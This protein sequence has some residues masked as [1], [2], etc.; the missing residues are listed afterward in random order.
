[1]TSRSPF[2]L[3][4]EGVTLI[5]DSSLVSLVWLS[6]SWQHR[7]RGGRYWEPHHDLGGVLVL[8]PTLSV[9]A[10]RGLKRRS[11]C[12]AGDPAPRPNVKKISV[13]RADKLICALRRQRNQCDR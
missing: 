8:T 7:D 10:K 11:T 12:G 5:K 1:M 2:A 4:N 13:K 3:V 6:W 9:L